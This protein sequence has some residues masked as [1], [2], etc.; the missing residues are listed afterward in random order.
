MNITLWTKCSEVA[1]IS[2][3]RSERSFKDRTMVVWQR[4]L[5]V[6]CWSGPSES[7]RV[8]LEAR[9]LT[10]S[11]ESRRRETRRWTWNTGVR[12]AA[13]L[14]RVGVLS[15]KWS[16]RLGTRIIEPRIKDLIAFNECYLNLIAKTFFREGGATFWLANREEMR[17]EVCLNFFLFWRQKTPHKTYL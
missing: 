10:S 1:W 16:R 12:V 5:T 4:L 9:P 17:P 7:Q 13:C 2:T 3:R 6:P 15:R 8:L 14:L 11:H